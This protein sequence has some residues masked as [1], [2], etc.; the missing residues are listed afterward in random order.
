MNP[1]PDDPDV[2]VIINCSNRGYHCVNTILLQC[3]SGVVLFHCFLGCR[4][5]SRVR[6]NSVGTIT[7]LPKHGL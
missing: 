3:N 6:L 1:L 4:L 5:D 7:A 2:M